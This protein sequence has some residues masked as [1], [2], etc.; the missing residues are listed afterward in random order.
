MYETLPFS[1][2]PTPPSFTD[3]ICP[4]GCSSCDHLKEFITI[5]IGLIE[6]HVDKHKYFKGIPD[7]ADG[8]AS[9]VEIYGGIIREMYC[10]W[11]CPKK[12][13]TVWKKLI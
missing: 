6:E 7:K 8:I 4:N 12:S 13:C 11:I 10:R 5:E 9:F 1:T 3:D 2:S